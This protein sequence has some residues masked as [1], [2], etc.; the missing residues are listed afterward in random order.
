MKF[1]NSEIKSSKENHFIDL[2]ISMSK[3]EVSSISLNDVRL[4]TTSKV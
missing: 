4:K 1:S 2:S 3:S